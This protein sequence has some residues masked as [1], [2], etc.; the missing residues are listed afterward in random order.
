[1]RRA[2][3]WL[4][5]AG[6]L[7]ACAP[8]SP[9][10]ARDLLQQALEHHGLATEP[11]VRLQGHGQIRRRVASGEFAGTF[12]IWM[13]GDDKLRRDESFFGAHATLVRL[14]SAVWGR[15][16]APLLDSERPALS[17]SPLALIRL[18]PNRAAPKLVSFEHEPALTTVFHHPRLGA[19]RAWFHPTDRSLLGLEFA[20]RG[21]RILLSFA[22]QGRSGSLSLPRHYVCFLDGAKDEEV[23]FEALRPDPKLSAQRFSTAGLTRLTPTR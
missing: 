6:W 21:R 18:A 5:A 10:A 23:T 9:G 4:L 1:M 8:R 22:L 15:G 11:V 7:S 12:R 2:L 13:D 14:G 3:A 16:A 17:A 20:E 19:V